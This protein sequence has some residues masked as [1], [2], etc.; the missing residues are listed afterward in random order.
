MREFRNVY[1]QRDP[2]W[3]SQRLGTVNGSTIGDYGCYVTSMAMLSCYYGHV[4]T[5]AQLDDILTDKNLYVNESGQYKAPANLMVDNNLTRVFP[6][7]TYQKTYD[8]SSKPADLGLLKKLSDD[9]NTTVIIGLDFDHNPANNI[10]YHF[11][12]LWKADATDADSIWVFDPWDG[13]T[14]PF[15]ASYGNDPALTIQKFVVYTGTPA[16]PQST[17]T[18]TDQTKISANLLNSVDYPV[19]DD[20]EIQ[21]IR[22][23]LSELGRLQKQPQ[24]QPQQQGQAVFTNPIS[25]LAYRFAV[26]LG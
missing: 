4:V 9:A 8:F 15:S 23:K 13:R 10:Q 1:C 7:I 26:W 24:P 6:D 20:M 12:A 22:G 3:A 17:V 19:T 16:Q 25:Q 11:V 14:K 21:A 18:F 5:P 2:K